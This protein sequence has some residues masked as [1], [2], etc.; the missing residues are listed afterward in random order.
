[1]ESLFFFF[2]LVDLF[3]VLFHG[4]GHGGGVRGVGRKMLESG[5]MFIITPRINFCGFYIF[6]SF[7]MPLL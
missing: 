4:F 5:N 2:S 7:R 3:Y 1:M 6:L